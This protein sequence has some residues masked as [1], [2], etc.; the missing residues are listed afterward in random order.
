MSADISQGVQLKCREDGWVRL[1]LLLHFLFVFPPSHSYKNGERERSHHCL[2]DDRSRLRNDRV[3]GVSGKSPCF[4]PGKKTNC[5]GAYR[6]EPCSTG[7]FPV[8]FFQRLTTL[9]RYSIVRPFQ[10]VG[11]RGAYSCVMSWCRGKKKVTSRVS[12]KQRGSEVCWTVEQ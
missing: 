5:D 4:T 7:Q 2:T 8:S 12:R 9:F 3:T 6:D 11:G 10:W 1:L